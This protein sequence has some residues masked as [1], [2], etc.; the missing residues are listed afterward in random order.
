[1]EL[2]AIRRYLAGA[3]SPS[4]ADAVRAWIAADP[5]AAAF[6]DALRSIVQPVQPASSR[7]WKT[8]AGWRRLVADAPGLVQP[9]RSG[10][11]FALVPRQSAIRVGAWAVPAADSDRLAAR[12]GRLSGKAETR[13]GAD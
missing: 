6:V 9:P 13:L 7:D 1:M 5:D 11:H 4:E 8:D 3:S 10:R 12:S 2:D